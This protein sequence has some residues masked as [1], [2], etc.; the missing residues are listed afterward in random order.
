[1][2]Y[3]A[4]ATVEEL[5]QHIGFLEPFGLAPRIEV[6]KDNIRHWHYVAGDDSGVGQFEDL[7]TTYMSQFE[8]NPNADLY[9]C[10]SEAILN[11]AY[12]AYPDGRRPGPQWWM[13][14][15]Q[16]NSRLFVAVYDTGIGIPSS[17]RRRPNF[18]E[19]FGDVIRIDP[20]RHDHKLIARA[21]ETSRSSTGKANQGKGL[22]E[23]LSFAQGTEGGR[24]YVISG[25]G[26]YRFDQSRGGALSKYAQA[27]LNG[28]LLFWSMPLAQDVQVVEVE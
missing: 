28:T 15:E 27:K 10:L 23:M 16:Q 17:L 11:V 9:G 18:V 22:P 5:L 13:L 3:P 20:R 25:H 8:D 4:D 26:E 24:F 14:A 7:V 12:W 21:V 19:Q 6:S 1:M 2:A